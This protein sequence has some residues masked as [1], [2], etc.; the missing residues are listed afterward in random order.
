MKH[1]NLQYPVIFI[2]SDL[3]TETTH[4]FSFHQISKNAILRL[5]HLNLFKNTIIVNSL[6][7][8]QASAKTR[9]SELT[10][11]YASVACKSPIFYEHADRYLE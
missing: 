10:P 7:N 11:I 2:E 8:S 6:K 4:D 3:M 5:F 1:L 9:A